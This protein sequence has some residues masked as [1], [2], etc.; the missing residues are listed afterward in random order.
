MRLCVYVCVSKFV[1]AVHVCAK[2][3]FRLLEFAV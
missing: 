1:C 2:I 3:N